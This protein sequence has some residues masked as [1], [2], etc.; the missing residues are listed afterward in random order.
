MTISL[1]QKNV[2]PWGQEDSYC[3]GAET[4]GDMGTCPHQVLTDFLFSLFTLDFGFQ[5]HTY[6]N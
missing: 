6:L 2:D 1:V 4:Y 5:L 3:R